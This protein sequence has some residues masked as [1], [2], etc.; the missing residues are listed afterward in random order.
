M[1]ERLPIAAWPDVPMDLSE[2]GVKKV[3]VPFDIARIA[4]QS[5]NGAANSVYLSSREDG[6]DPRA[7]EVADNLAYGWQQ[8]APLFVHVI[9]ATTG[10]TLQLLLGA[11]GTDIYPGTTGGSASLNRS[12]WM[13]GSWTKQYSDGWTVLGSSVLIPGGFGLAIKND[14]NSP[15]YVDLRNPDRSGFYRLHPGESLTLQISNVTLVEGLAEDGAGDCT[16]YYAVEL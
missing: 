8:G 14:Q 9:E 15:G 13:P 2:T 3:H 5:F 12:D 11:P 6:N 16:L 10:A 7:I 1:S 4:V